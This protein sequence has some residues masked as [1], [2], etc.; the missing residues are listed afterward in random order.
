L[1]FLLN[2]IR[3][4]VRKWW[5]GG[6]LVGRRGETAFE[7]EPLALDGDLDAAVKLRGRGFGSSA[8]EEPHGVSG[9]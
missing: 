5:R 6:D 2:L 7:R 9:N 4:W 3:G 8:W 1:C